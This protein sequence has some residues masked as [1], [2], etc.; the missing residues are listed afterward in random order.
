M[1]DN[2]FDLGGHS[3]LAT[4]LIARIEKTLGSVSLSTLFQSPTIE[5]LAR[6]LRQKK[7]A[8]QDSA[9]VLFRNGGTQPPLFLHGGSLELSRYLAD[10]Q[11][12]Y[13]IRPHG[14]DGR[15]A[16]TTVEEMAADYLRQIRSVQPQ[17]P[18]LIG[19]FSFGGLVAYEM[20]QQLRQS[21]RKSGCWF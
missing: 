4:R 15:R 16:P 5:S 3:L 20:A 14:Q 13:G 17:G 18:Y 12:C 19:G 8:H 2:F 21:G 1:K 7:K 9:L 11:P 10:D 6:E